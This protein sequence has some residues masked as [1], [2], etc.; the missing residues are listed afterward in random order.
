[1]LGALTLTFGNLEP[2]FLTPP[3]PPTPTS[4]LPLCSLQPLLQ[5]PHM[6]I[7]RKT[8]NCHPLIKNNAF[9][10]KIAG[11]FLIIGAD[12]SLVA[13]STPLRSA[14]GRKRLQW[15]SVVAAVAERHAP[16][17]VRCINDGPDRRLT[18]A[19][20]A[21]ITDPR[22][23]FPCKLLLIFHPPVG[24]Y[25]S[26]APRAAADFPINWYRGVVCC[27]AFDIKISLKGIGHEENS[28]KT[29]K[30]KSLSSGKLK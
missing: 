26:S 3:P 17:V 25:A 16:I 4:L 22:R 12:D 28:W 11:N 9:L 30:T 24:D 19:V 14:G 6:T 21:Q 27:F 18:A 2:I 15:A 20:T 1:M 29:G 8:R 7:D 5:F 23:T 13:D 10:I